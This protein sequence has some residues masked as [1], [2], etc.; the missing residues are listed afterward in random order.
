MTQETICRV[1][2]FTE[3]IYPAAVE[4][5]AFSDFRVVPSK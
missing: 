3:I 1:A 2:R 4:G 5:I